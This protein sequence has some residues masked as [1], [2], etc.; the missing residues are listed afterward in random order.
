MK[1]TQFN[2]LT[3]LSFL[4]EFFFFLISASQLT[5]FLTIKVDVGLF[6]NN[7]KNKS[8]DDCLF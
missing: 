4:G 8:L 5:F 6:R 2:E 1:A 7:Q 3:K